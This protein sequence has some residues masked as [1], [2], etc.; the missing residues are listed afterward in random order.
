MRDH[1]D[2]LLSEGHFQLIRKEDAKAAVQRL[3]EALPVATRGDVV[4]RL[5]TLFPTRRTELLLDERPIV[6]STEA[7]ARV[8]VRRGIATAVG[9]NAYF[10]QA[11]SVATVAKADVDA[12]MAGVEDRET[13]AAALADYL[14]RRDED[15]APLISAFLEELRFR[16][17]AGGRITQPLLDAML[18]IGEPVMR[19]DS[20]GG[21]YEDRPLHAWDS[22][23]ATL[24]QPLKPEEAGPMLK[25]ALD[26][27]LAAS[28]A[29]ELYVERG[30]ELEVFPRVG[31]ASPLISEA[32]FEALGPRVLALILAERDAGIRRTRS[33]ERAVGLR[34]R[35][36]RP[37]HPGPR[38]DL[39]AEQR[40]AKAA[41][42]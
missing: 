19:Q 17:E 14:S 25:L 8:V 12:V 38:S 36:G 24:F 30:R 5:A 20:L 35:A 22:L 26:R 6:G 3:H 28:V 23:L 1:R 13:I 16:F 21:A 11:G 4:G 10:A 2:W 27:P 37:R 32:D 15:E 31:Q 40:D 9:F 33:P 29:A 18:A 34:T 41:T 42:A 7:Y 39:D